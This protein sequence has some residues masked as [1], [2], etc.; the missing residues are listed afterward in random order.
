MNYTVTGNFRPDGV[1]ALACINPGKKGGTWT[2]KNGY[3]GSNCNT[4]YFTSAIT[5]YGTTFDPVTSASLPG[6]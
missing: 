5:A 6:Y 2:P 3:T 4:T 1:R